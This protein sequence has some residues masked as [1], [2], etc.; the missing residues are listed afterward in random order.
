MQ[1]VRK[2][3]KPLNVV[4]CGVESVLASRLRLSANWLNGMTHPYFY[5][6][7]PP[8]IL[9]LTPCSWQ[10]VKCAPE[11]VLLPQYR[12]NSIFHP[13]EGTLVQFTLPASHRYTHAHIHTSTASYYLPAVLPPICHDVPPSVSC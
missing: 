6:H 5:P 11:K 10:L 7:N 9:T 13:N 4:P 12:Q 3:P 1:G 8:L 2:D